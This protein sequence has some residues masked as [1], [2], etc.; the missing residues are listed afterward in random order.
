MTIQL[1]EEIAYVL[2]KKI[3]DHALGSREE[4]LD[5]RYE[6]IAGLDTNPTDLLAHIDYLNQKGYVN[7]QFSGDAYANKG[8]NPLPHLISLQ[9]ATL[10]PLGKDLLARMEANPPAS[11][12]SGPSVPIASEEMAFLEKIQ[13]KGN[14]NDIYDARDITEVVFRTMRDLMNQETV[15]EIAQGLQ[16]A[17][18]PKTDEKALQ[19]DVAEL[20]KDRNRLV[21]FL[22]NLRPPLDFDAETFL[23]RIRQEAGL[24]KS[25]GPKTVL[26]AVFS[27]TK[28]ELDADLVQTIS[29]V[30]PGEIRSLWEAA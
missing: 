9:S 21:R 15:E 4:T 2:L 11:L 22:S 5:L 17:A 29:R 28:E 7:A 8:P 6:D 19:T 26:K 25:T 27:A 12:A 13:L 20:W 10:T 24:P 23:Y 30:L 3:D 16:V 14:L 18:L 1:K